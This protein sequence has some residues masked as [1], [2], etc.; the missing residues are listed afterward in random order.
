MMTSTIDKYLVQ[1]LD[2]TQLTGIYAYRGQQDSECP[3][4]S[5]ATRRLIEEHGSDI[6]RDPEFPQLY[7]NYHGETLIYPARTRGFGFESG[8]RLSDL[9]LL[10]KLQHFGAATGLLDFTWSPLVA[11]WFACEDPSRDGKLFLVDTND[12]MRVSRV[13][14]DETAQQMDAVFSKPAGPPHLSYWEPMVSGDASA[15]ILRQRSVFIIARPL[16]SVDTDIIRE[17]VVTKNDKEPLQLELQILDF[18]QES[19]FQDVYGFAQASTRSPVPPLTPEAYQRRGNR[20][21]QRGEYAEAT[22]AY[23][24]SIELAPNVG[25][26]YLLRGNVHAACGHHQEAI[27]DYDK[28]VAHVSQLHPI[29]QD[30]VFFNR[31]N[32]KTELS[33]YDGAL[34]DYTEAI[35]INPN[36]SQAYY[37]RGNTY[38]DLYRF[39]EAL[40][41][42]DRVTG[43]SSQDTAFNKGNALVAMGRWPEARRCYLDADAK[44]VDHEGIAQNLGTLEQIMLVV[45]D[46][47]Y[48]VRAVPD[49]DTSTM[50]LRFEMPEEATE[51]GQSLERFLFFGRQGNVGNTGGPGLSGGEGSMG[52]PFVRVYINVGTKKER[53][54]SS[55]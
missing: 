42:Y 25:L 14:S 34:Q 51:K 39:G 36:L 10:A 41:D 4:H 37:N 26:T 33:D 7:I 30:T 49:S 38:V 24:K 45:E 17:I 52:K 12:V 46:L 3:L 5:A 31:G 23:N 27:K 43:H 44:G 47:E 16:L 8:R 32:S 6:V 9:E 50:C 19:L 55:V 54:A 21:Y 1:I 48:T 18:H 28:A 22:V 11:L 13:S 2:A 15:R 35:S 53:D 40:L 29:I 20:H